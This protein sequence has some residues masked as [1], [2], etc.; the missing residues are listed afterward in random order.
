MILKPNWVENSIHSV[1]NSLLDDELIRSC[2]AAK[3]VQVERDHVLG[4]VESVEANK[5]RFQSRY[6]LALKHYAATDSLEE[7]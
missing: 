3:T 2:F 1:T 7:N 5:S 4:P 6:F